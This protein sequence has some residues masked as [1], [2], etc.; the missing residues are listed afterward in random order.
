MG[1]GA[2]PED[3]HV[4]A[5]NDEI[6]DEVAGGQ[7]LNH[8]AGASVAPD[9]LLGVHGGALVVGVDDP[10]G[11]GI[12]EAALDHGDDMGVPVDA[13]TAGEG[14]V[15]V[16]SKEGRKDGREGPVDDRVEEGAGE[17]LVHVVWQRR[18]GQGI[19]QRL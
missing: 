18:E 6:P 8:A 11:Q 13:P 12:D 10:K 14:R 19:S 4:A 17:D 2:G 15:L 9:T 1:E 7:C 16:A 3:V 5:G